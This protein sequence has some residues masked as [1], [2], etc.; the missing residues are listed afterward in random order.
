MALPSSKTSKT[1]RRP[2][3]KTIAELSG[4]AMTTVSRALS[5]APDISAETKRLVRK[6]AD[7]VGYVPDRAGV[8]LRTGRTNVIALIV[9]MEED[10]LNMTSRLIAAIAGELSNTRYHLVVV[11]EMPGQTLLDPVRY[12]VETRSADAVIF[13]R[14]QPRDPRISYLRDKGFP[15]ATHGRSD[16]LADHAWFDYDNAGFGRRAVMELA[17]RGRRN[18]LLIAPPDSETYGREMRAGAQAGAESCGIALHSP[19]GLTSDSPRAMVQTAVTTALAGKDRPDGM[20]VASPNAALAVIS[21][22]EEAGHSI[23]QDIDIFAKE[24]FPILDV[25]NR[26][27][28]IEHEDVRKA[29][30]FLARAALNEITTGGT[31]HLQQIDGASE[32]TAEP[33]SGSSAP[34]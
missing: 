17:A 7:D 20:I 4:L 8:R 2:T 3:L 14:V 25:L 34:P 18:I 29:G 19:D 31:A 11:P 24:T 32:L 33:V 21:A 22:L 26:H 27:I 10:A 6:I 28:M 5:D 16:W 9:P 1:Q 30:V 13:N 12:V 15:F 23:G